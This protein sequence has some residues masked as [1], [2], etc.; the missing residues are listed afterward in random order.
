MEEV[1]LVG[2]GRWESRG[3]LEMDVGWLAVEGWSL[4]VESRKRVS[5]GRLEFGG[6]KWEKGGI[7]MAGI[8][9]YMSIW[10]Q[11]DVHW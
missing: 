4:E 8:H 9:S 10:G 1:V 11:V 3:W 6:G 7:A 5:C 2:S